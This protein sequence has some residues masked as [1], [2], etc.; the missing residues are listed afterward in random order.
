MIVYS[1]REQIQ[2]TQ[3]L[4]EDAFNQ[5]EDEDEPLNLPEVCIENI[6]SIYTIVSEADISQKDAF[7]SLLIENV[8]AYMHSIE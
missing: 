2:Q 3:E 1:R 5:N 4:T 7:H 8:F 6:H